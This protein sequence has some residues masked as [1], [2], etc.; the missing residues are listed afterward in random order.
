MVPRNIAYIYSRSIFGVINNTIKRRNKQILKHRIRYLYFS[1]FIV[2]RRR[3]FNISVAD[4]ASLLTSNWSKTF[5]SECQVY[6]VIPQWLEC[7]KNLNI[8]MYKKRSQ[9]TII[10]CFVQLTRHGVAGIFQLLKCVITQHWHQINWLQIHS[11]HKYPRLKATD[12]VTKTSSQSTRN[13][14]ES[15]HLFF[16]DR[17]RR[18]W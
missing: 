5:W 2:E 17:Y 3:K 14:I 8:R 9:I 11:D 7:L 18:F 10:S 1:W 4:V 13:L 16:C 12:L 15:I 6:L